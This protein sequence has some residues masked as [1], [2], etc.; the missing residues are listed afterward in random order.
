MP[1]DIKRIQAICFDVDGTLSDTDDLF[2]YR[3]YTMLRPLYGSRLISQYAVHGLSRWMVM[4]METP[5]NLAYAAVDR[6]RM[7]DAVLNP[8]KVRLKRKD[9]PPPSFWLIEG[10]AEMLTALAGRYPLAVVTARDEAGTMAF[11]EQ[12]SLTGLFGAVATARTCQYT[13]PFPDPVV[14]AAGE[15]GVAPQDCLMVGDTTVDMR[16]GKAAG[17]QTV[18]VL[19]G[20]G[21][22]RELLRAGA[23]L[24]LPMTADLMGVLA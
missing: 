22:E 18:G 23:D 11:L 21:R 9:K 14:W 17:A 6:T 4:A 1:L 10:V 12:F 13:K 20:F 16:A 15:L 7:D 5:S 24:I 2:V 3:L 19:C 8:L